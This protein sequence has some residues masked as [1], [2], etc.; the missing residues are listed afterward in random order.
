LYRRRL[1]LV[2]QWLVRSRLDGTLVAMA[3]Q[4]I[5]AQIDRATLWA[6]VCTAEALNASGITDPYELYKYMHPSDVGTCIGTLEVV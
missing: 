5:V 2:A 4:K 3:Y 1:S 6:L